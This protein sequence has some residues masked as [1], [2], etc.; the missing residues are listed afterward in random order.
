MQGA[1]T[2]TVKL[3]LMGANVISGFVLFSEV[4]WIPINKIKPH[5]ITQKESVFAV[6]SNY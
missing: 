6:L 1:P 2:N 5:A 4:M 3:V